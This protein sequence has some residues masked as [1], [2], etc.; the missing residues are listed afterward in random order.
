[1]GVE[2]IVAV[3]SAASAAMAYKGMKNAEKAQKEQKNLEKDRKAK[4]EAE[5][6]ARVAA[7]KEAET[8]GQRAGTGAAPSMR[9]AFLSTARGGTTGF[10]T[11]GDT[12]REDVIGR[13]TLFGN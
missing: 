13:A 11:A 9:Q 7:A 5:E 1:M 2:T 4:L 8:L 6:R 10:S 12:A 3:A